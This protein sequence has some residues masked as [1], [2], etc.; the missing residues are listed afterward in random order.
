M[1][2][3]ADLYDSYLPPFRAGLAAG[4][5]SVMSGLNSVNGVPS[6]ANRALLTGL[7]RERWGFGGFVVSDWAAIL[8]LVQHG[9]AR[10]GP[11]A[12]RKALL[13]GID[14]DM[15]SRLYSRFLAGE[16]SAGRVPAAL[17]DQAARRVI[18][19]KLGMGLFE[20]PDLDPAQPV[21]AGPSTAMRAA[22]RAAARDTLVLL[23]NE[24]ALPLSGGGRIA[25][26]GGMAESGR[27]LTGPH[28]AMVRFEDAPAILTAMAARSV[29]GGGSLAFAA[30]CSPECSSE[31]GFD[32]AVSIAREADLV[33]AVLG[34]PLDSTGEAASRASLRL[35]GGQAELLTRLVETG[36]P[37]V[38][39][40]LS[41]RPLELGPIADR[42]AA[43]LMAWFPGTEGAAALADVLFGDH[44]PSARL[45]VTWPRSVGQ[46]PLAYDGVPSG[47]PHDPDNR[48][49]LRYVDEEV[50]PL[51]AFGHG[52]TYT[53]FAYSDLRVVTPRIGR[54][55]TLEVS[56]HLTNVGPRSGREVAQLYVRQSVAS[57]AR[58]VRQLKGFRKVALE[59][60]QS[61]TVTFRVPAAELGFHLDDGSYVVEPGPFEIHVGASVA[62]TLT[63]TFELED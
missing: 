35:P 16:V 29:R 10:D 53:R 23:R 12:A 46:V 34:E 58:P 21:P 45:P 22:A 30:G 36:K 7:L 60:G 61:E 24:G 47:R 44:A 57:R 11:E 62:D 17:V 28:G 50:T 27:D 3:P 6:T 54:D 43:L 25:L 55:G 49:T 5:E 37:V 14:M 26:I 20:R 4:S 41:T 2:A 59:P 19:A 8:E 38:V 15:E 9:V 56:V 42:L 13:A 52:L 63:G 32:Q 39:V 33:V 31:A 40:L 51:F 1:I 18:R 48:F